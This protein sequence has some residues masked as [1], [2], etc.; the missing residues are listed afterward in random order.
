MRELFRDGKL[1]SGL[2]PGG[3]PEPYF[4]KMSNDSE[5]LDHIFLE[6]C[7]SM[8]DRDIVVL[9]TSV[10]SSANGLCHIIRGGRHG[11]EEHG[12]KMPI[13]MGYT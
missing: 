5:F 1:D 3:N 4:A 9:P 8:L 6:V 12:R 2:F 7:S 13:F 11:S 10:G